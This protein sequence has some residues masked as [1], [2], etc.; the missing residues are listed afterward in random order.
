MSAMGLG[1]F[2]SRWITRSI[3]R[4]FVL[5]EV[6]I[7]LIGGSSAAL[8]YAVFATSGFYHMTMVLLILFVGSMIGM[9][10][11][12]LTRLSGGWKA[13]KDTLAN[14]LA[15]D[16]LG[17]LLGSILFP[18]VLLPKLG[19]LKTSFVIG[20]LNMAVA[21]LN[22]WTFRRQLARWRRLA[23]TVGVVLAS[24]ATSPYFARETYWCI[25]HTASDAHQRTDAVGPLPGQPE[26][27]TAHMT[28]GRH[29]QLR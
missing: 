15:F 10:I 26:I 28:V 8:L 1:S 23:A 11:P 29:S 25:V 22:V 5:L 20:L 9:E 6:A 7:G 24:Q 18:L 13:L 27:L 3:L 12:L 2:A 14:V 19:L 4:W 17:A 21:A 16:Y